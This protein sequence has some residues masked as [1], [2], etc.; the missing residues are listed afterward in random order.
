M[1]RV[2]VQ[3]QIE[4]DERHRA[5]AALREAKVAA[6]DALGIAEAAN[7]AKSVFLANMSHELR[8]PLNAI[9][10]FS[11]LMTFSSNLSPEQQE[12]LETIG[13]S[14]DVLLSIINNI[15]DFSKI[16]AGRMEVE[17]QPVN[18][19][20]CVE[21]SLDMLAVKAAEKGLEMK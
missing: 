18:L 20:D 1:Q 14:G 17:T 19:R 13:H 9:L 3:L 21:N 12:N 10:G 6:E 11:E 16:E 8:T 4:I 15:L 5:E 7:R 2:N